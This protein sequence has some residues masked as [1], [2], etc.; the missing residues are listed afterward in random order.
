[1]KLLRFFQAKEIELSPYRIAKGEEEYRVK[2]E[3]LSTI[4]KGSNGT[5]L[6]AIDERGT[7]RERNTENA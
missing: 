4:Q 5:A 1:M 7:L 3:I 2:R 6:V